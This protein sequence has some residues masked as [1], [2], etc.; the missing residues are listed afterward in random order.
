[1]I[2]AL[3]MFKVGK[4]MI[5]KLATQLGAI[6]EV[7]EVLSI[8][9]EYDLIAKIQVKEYESLSD[10]VTEK[11]Q[12]IDGVL[13]TKTIT[14]FKT[15]K[16]SEL[17]E[18]APAALIA[19]PPSPEDMV[20]VIETGKKK[21]KPILSKLTQNF[22][23]E[24]N[25]IYSV[26]DAINAGELTDVQIAGFLVGL[27]SKGPSIKEVAYIAQAMRNNCVPMKV[28]LNSDL[29][30]TCGTG[31]GLATFNVST[32]SAI[33]TAAAGVLVAKH[34]SRSISS[35]SG[36]ADVLESLGVNINLTPEQAS[37]LIE[38]CGISFI[39][40]PNFHPVML[41]V[42]GPENQLGIKSI[43][44][45]II[46]PLINPLRARNHTI[47]VYKPELVSLMADVVSEMDFNHVIVA[48][49]MDGLD[50]ISLIGKTLVAEIKNKQ[51]KHYELSPEDFGMKR[52]TL[53]DIAGG[54]PDFN[55]QVIRDIFVGKER[56]PRRDFLTLNN[57]AALY[58]S[59]KVPS[60]QEGIKLSN[61][62]LYSKAALRKLEELAAKSNAF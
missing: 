15:Y 20:E 41:K 24:R 5:S 1:M 29:T 30:D 34:G 9:G 21:I 22:D 42:F 37:R 54:S 38:D 57:G 2:T 10:I 62:L 16:F 3:T 48:H 31:G 18:G 12:N 47:G 44:F 7:V 32:A 13:E 56:G 49:G 27:L 11:M 58:V 46:G 61:Y 8:T 26:I 43:F 35:S 19:T 60:I 28:S 23:L 40:A 51:I 17:A 53:E 36:S 4:G 52:C 39:Y 25:E 55:A 59:G 50:E 33:L 14:A 6:D 45:T